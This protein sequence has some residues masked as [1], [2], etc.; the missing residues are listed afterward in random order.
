MQKPCISQTIGERIKI[1]VAEMA[2]KA[3][4]YPTTHDGN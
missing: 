2:A 1:E 3:C 4:F